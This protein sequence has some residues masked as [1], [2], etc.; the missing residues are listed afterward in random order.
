[1]CGIFG[2]VFRNP[3]RSADEAAVI[4][5]R[6]TLQH[7][8]PDE[9]G[10]WLRPGVAFAH[11]R[12]KV[13][14]LQ[15][16]QQPM[17]SADGQRALVYNGE[18]YNFAALREDYRRRGISF[19]S[20]SDTEVVL[21]AL[22]CDGTAAIDQ[23]NG[24]FALGHW[25]QRQR[26]LLLVRDRLGQK[27]LYWYSDDEQLVFASEL[28]AVLEYLQRR[29]DIDPVALD[30]YFAR[31]YI[32]SPRTIFKGINKLPAGH[33]LE[34]DTR[35]GQ[36]RWHVRQYWDH[37]PRQV[38]QD[39]AEALDELDALLTDAVRM[40]LVSDVPIGCL[41]SGG[42]DS[43][44]ITAIAA[45]AMDEPVNAFTIGF[46]ESESFDEVP[47]A[48]MVAEQFDCNWRVKQ[49]CAD[50]FRS[51]LDDMGYYFDEPFCNF[52][53][54][55]MRQL[56]QLAR[57]ELVVVLSGQGGDELSAGY[58]GRYGWAADANGS[59]GQGT[60]FLIDH[61]TQHLHYTSILPW[62]AARSQ[63]YS[64][65]L[66][67]AVRRAGTPLTGMQACWSRYGELGQLNEALYVDVKSNLPDYLVCVEERM[68]M[69]ASLE[70]RNPMLDYRL[71]DFMLSLPPRMKVRHG[72]HKWILL[73]LAKRYG[74]AQ[75][76][77]RPKRGFTPPI[78]HWMTQNADHVAEVLK[79][80][81]AQTAGL[82]A[83]NWRSYQHG[84]SY[85]RA[86]TMSLL[87][88]LMLAKWVQ[89]YERFIGAWPVAAGSPAAGSAGST[90]ADSDTRHWHRTLD[91]HDPV[92]MAEARLFEQA[93]KNLQRGSHIRL[94]GDVKGWYAFLA[95][96]CGMHVLPEDAPAEAS[97]SG[98]VVVGLAA[99][100]GLLTNGAKVAQEL[101]AGTL[102]LM[103]RFDAKT[104]QQVEALLPQLA[105]SWVLAGCQVV[106]LAQDHQGIVIRA[107]AQS[108][109]AEAG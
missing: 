66:I 84:G 81:D 64:P 46:G 4:A 88:C 76:V 54:F 39:D 92:L 93:L 13:L 22:G 28:K 8:G 7:R 37:R 72:Q 29:F 108:S 48:R 104:K 38:P 2:V 105:E 17:L 12:L 20:N 90:D 101:G 9:A 95:Q 56:A 83:P 75:A 80:T 27:P 89:R 85:D 10:A 3:D 103:T 26:H 21:H 62:A 19:T 14:D 1:M 31:G 70:A 71:V 51:Q 33:L 55:P 18:I 86:Q 23:F 47:Y 91:E 65:G 74:L 15:R 11:Q 57:S 24:M 68:T 30:Q 5:A 43:S 59:G 44:L 87:Y 67:D 36:W 50:D 16:G 69:A 41:L 35:P 107:A 63:M 60:P 79:A 94:I 82:Y 97:L 96:G 49:V 52:A 6:R 99:I 34:L 106:H 98:I 32:L 45:G 77:D 102:L 73:E 42:I 61:V 78:V 40:R 58:P 25:D 100:T 109:L 53:M